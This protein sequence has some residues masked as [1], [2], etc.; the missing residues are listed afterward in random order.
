LKEAQN[1][2]KSFTTLLVEL[3]ERELE[4]R[5]A[6]ATANRLVRARFPED[7]TLETFPWDRQPGVSRSQI[8]EL[9]E[10]EFVREAT[11][12][13]LIGDV[14]V[15]KTGLAI[16]LS[17]V[18]VLTGYTVLFSKV[19]DLVDGL[20][21]SVVERS[22]QRA[23]RRLASI[24]VLV[25]DELSYVT[26]NEEQAN[27]LFKLVD[28]RYRRKSTILT[29]NLGFDDWRTFLPKKALESALKDRVTDQ[30][31]VLRIEGP[32]LRSGPRKSPK[33][34]GAAAAPEC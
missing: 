26:F 2:R 20:Y 9:A 21:A 6:R 18:A 15:G 1:R 16:G 14:G 10:L 13:C 19:S 7:W 27:L 5:E 33:E 30:C 32:T 23:L 24:D 8:M 31:H 12:I 22:T 28:A 17:R 4:G 29:C 25:L 3:L 34:K 11:N